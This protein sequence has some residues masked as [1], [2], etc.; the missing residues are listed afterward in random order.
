MTEAIRSHAVRVRTATP[1]DWA[2]VGALTVAVQGPDEP[3]D[4]VQRLGDT[5]ALARDRDVR[6][7][8]ATDVDGTIVGS[9]TTTRFGSGWAGGGLGPGEGGLR[10]LAVAPDA[11]GRGAG[12]ALVRQGL[13]VARADRLDRVVTFTAADRPAAG[14]LLGRLG[15]R[16]LPW[17]DRRATDGVKLLAFGI[18]LAPI[19]VRPAEAAE[20]DRAGRL[21]LAGYVADGIVGPSDGYARHLAD[22]AGRAAAA[23]LLV[24]VDRAGEVVGTVTFCRPG[25]PYAELSRPG[26]AEFRMLAV[27]PSAR[28]SGVGTALVHACLDLAGAAGD[29][30]LVLSTLAEMRAAARLYQRLGF[31]ADPARDWSPQPGVTLLAYQRDV[32]PDGSDRLAERR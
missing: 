11:R 23:T 21:T 10:L 27:G 6:L 9:V 5:A 3:A 20:L 18:D 19:V 15:F 4:L 12:A 31:T 26:E 7:L 30:T 8:V 17:R 32:L 24:A 14:R 25:S 22:A 2:A 16:R 29:R 1:A 13:E 28:G